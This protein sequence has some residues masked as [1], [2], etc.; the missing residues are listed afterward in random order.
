MARCPNGSRKNKEG[1]CECKVGWKKYKSSCVPKLTPNTTKVIKRCPTGSRKNKN[2]IC[3]CK[4]K[5]KIFYKGVCINKDSKDSKNN[6][7]NISV[8]KEYYSPNTPIPSPKT[9][10]PVETNQL[11]E[12]VKTPIKTN[13]TKKINQ[14]KAALKIQKTTTM[15]I[16]NKLKKIC[17]NISDCLLIGKF[18]PYIL[19]WFDNFNLLNADNIVTRIGME[20]NNGFI[21]ELEYNVNIYI[22]NQNLS[23]K[24]Y[25]ILKSNVYRYTDNL[26]YEFTIG[27][28]LNKFHKY[29]PIFI[30]TYN[31]YKYND[32]DKK[33]DIFKQTSKT[34]DIVKITNKNIYDLLDEVN[35][36]SL[37]DACN[38]SE[39]YAFTSQII[40][41]STSLHD[42]IINKQINNYDLAFTI[43]QI[44]FCI[45]A[46]NK[47]YSFAHYDLHA[48]NVLLYKPFGENYIHYRFHLTNTNEV[49]DIYSYYMIKVIDYGRT[50]VE[51]STDL[52]N[53][54]EKEI[55]KKPCGRDHGK[56]RGFFLNKHMR[57][58]IFI[59]YENVNLSHDLRLLENIKQ[60]NLQTIRYSSTD[61]IPLFNKLKYSVGIKNPTF[62]GYGTEPNN[63]PGGM[64]S[65]NNI[66]DVPDNFWNYISHHQIN[67]PQNK[68]KAVIDIYDDIKTPLNLKII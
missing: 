1:I 25:A 11:L 63:T 41:N 6:K 49:R 20:S 65:I 24:S 36:T 48:G 32:T 30:E 27:K 59:D 60:L 10:T 31:L 50:H 67:P 57:N 23:Y 61:I 4:D 38:K 66:W 12:I 58:N 9:L 56:D 45:C 22:Q 52:F 55:Y 28:Y 35:N 17:P 3:E 16:L 33:D 68:I 29:I 26:W 7:N 42:L 14:T 15:F 47:S 18:R 5:T 51:Q 34:I 62:N 8:L 21:L 39:D 40:Q 44:F 13:I 19:K 46:L 64:N 54:L 53:E 37:L 43:Y 2:K